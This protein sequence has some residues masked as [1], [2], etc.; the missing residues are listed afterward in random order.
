MV[1]IIIEE[2]KKRFFLSLCYLYNMQ[3]IRLQK[4]SRFFGYYQT[5]GMTNT[6]LVLR[7]NGTTATINKIIYVQNII[8]TIK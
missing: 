5:R 2:Q 7:I 8:Y 4:N 3:E 6:E 1:E